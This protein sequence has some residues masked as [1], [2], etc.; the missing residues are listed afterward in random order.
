M[1][2]RHMRT[3]LRPDGTSFGEL[4]ISPISKLS[5]NQSPTPE[6]ESILGNCLTWPLSH[7]SPMSSSQSLNSLPLLSSHTIQAINSGDKIQPMRSPRKL[8]KKLEKCSYQL[9]D[10]KKNDEILKQQQKI[11]R[12]TTISFLPSIINR[13]NCL[14]TNLIISTLQKNLSGKTFY[15]E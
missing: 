3:H 10:L 11:N 8:K 15:V 14:N 9:L 4:L 13:S 2:T 6:P 12:T 5:L 1:I 7:L